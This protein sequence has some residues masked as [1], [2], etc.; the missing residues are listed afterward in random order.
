[1]DEQQVRRRAPPTDSLRPFHD[2]NDGRNRMRR[3]HRGG[4]TGRLHVRPVHLPRRPQDCHTRQEPGRRSARHHFAHRQ[5]PRSRQGHDRAGAARSDADAGDRVRDRLPPVSGVH[6]RL[7]GRG[8]AEIQQDRVH[9]RGDYQGQ[10][11]GASDGGYGTGVPAVPGGGGVPR[12]GGVVLRDVR[13]GVLP[14]FRGGRV[15]HE[16]G[17]HGGGHVPYQI[18]LDRPLDHPLGAACA[19]RPSREGTPGPAECEALG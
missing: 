11:V 15:R 14:R 12:A 8:R 16:P 3:G 4:R 18:R 19:G 6:D 9:P 17:G 13:R 5:L 1:M 7:R 10:S 2:G